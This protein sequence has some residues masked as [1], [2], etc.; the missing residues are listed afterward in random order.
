MDLVRLNDFLATI[1]GYIG[2]SSWFVFVLLGSGVFFTI[3]LKFP[4]IRYF[5]H[6]IAV[7][8]GKFDRKGACLLYTSDAADE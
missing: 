4:Q 2:G 5:S 8:K 7:V 6:A 3:Y 1:D